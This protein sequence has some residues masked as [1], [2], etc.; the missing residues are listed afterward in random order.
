M[1]D[2][3]RFAKPPISRL[4]NRLHVLPPRQGL[5]LKFEAET[6]GG[7]ITTLV[8]L[9][10][11]R[12]RTALISRTPGVLEIADTDIEIGRGTVLTVGS[13]LNS[14]AGRNAVEMRYSGPRTKSRILDCNAPAVV[15]SKLR[16]KAILKTVEELVR[17]YQ[18]IEGSN[19]A[20]HASGIDARK[21]S[22]TAC[23]YAGPDIASLF[24]ELGLASGGGEPLVGYHSAMNARGGHDTMRAYGAQEMLT[25]T[26][27][28][29][30]KISL[31]KRTLSTGAVHVISYHP[32]GQH[33]T[34]QF[35]D[36]DEPIGAPNEVSR[37]DD[38]ATAAMKQA[39]LI[40]RSVTQLLPRPAR[41]LS[42]P[43]LKGDG[44]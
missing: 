36:G 9:T 43:V 5:S 6:L 42:P 40:V 18:L 26:I 17:P 10:G 35:Y 21:A 33:V 2:L 23:F 29:N 31:A 15:N 12:Y 37:Q 11:E 8:E 25:L 30:G 3:S 4:F 34:S 1:T 39:D 20:R 32:T 13:Q 44:R 24:K 7:S 28:E 19:M 14:D 22:T 38:R 27:P 16:A 41:P